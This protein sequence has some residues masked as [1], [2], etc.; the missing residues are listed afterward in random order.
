MT[1]QRDSKGRFVKK[2]AEIVPTDDPSK[3]IIT[4]ILILFGILALLGLLYSHGIN[5]AYADGYALGSTDAE[6]KTFDDAFNKGLEFGNN[7]TTVGC[8]GYW[9]SWYYNY[10]T[11]VTRACEKSD[12]YHHRVFDSRYNVLDEY[13]AW[14]DYGVYGVGGS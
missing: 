12:P 7:W 10:R 4:A 1:P 2:S 5:N 8:K 14:N 13:E 11:D 6:T 3:R 9:I